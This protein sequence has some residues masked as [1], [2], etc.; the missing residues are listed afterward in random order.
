M[1]NT[2]V[3]TRITNLRKHTN[4]DKLQ[5]GSVLGNPVIVGLDIEE[6][7][8]GVYFDCNVALS[9]EYLSNNNL[10]HTSLLNKDK[11]KSGFFQENGRVKCIKLRGEKSDGFWVELSTLEFTNC[12][13]NKLSENYEFDEL[14]KIPICHKYVT[15]ASTKSGGIKNQI[16]DKVKVSKLVFPEHR[17]E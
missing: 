15:K 9:P 8:L 1:N 6:N 11:D 17:S 14:N 12:N 16:K 7:T 10:Y 3:I 4:A 5:I 2:A 13:M